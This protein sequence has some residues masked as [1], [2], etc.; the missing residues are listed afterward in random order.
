VTASDTHRAIDAVWRIESPRVIAGVDAV[1]RKG[2]VLHH[3]RMS[4]LQGIA[5]ERDAAGHLLGKLHVRDDVGCPL[6]QLRRVRS[7]SVEHE[8]LDTGIYTGL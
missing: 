2:G 8:A 3:D 4:P 5:D 6:L 7:H 1:G